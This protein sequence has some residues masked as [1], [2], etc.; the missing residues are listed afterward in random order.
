[1][2]Y[3]RY[4]DLNPENALRETVDGFTRRFQHVEQSLAGQGVTIDQADLSEMRQLWTE[5]KE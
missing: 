3:A 2:N 5:T 1:V 4:A